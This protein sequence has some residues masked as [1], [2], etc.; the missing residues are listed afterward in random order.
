MAADAHHSEM[1]PLKL[2][3]GGKPDHISGIIGARGGV[4]PP[5]REGVHP[6]SWA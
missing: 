2:T 1:G 6:F 4:P 5:G 3:M